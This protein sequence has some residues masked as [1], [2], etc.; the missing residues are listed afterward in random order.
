MSFACKSLSYSKYLIN[1]S[2]CDGDDNN[3]DDDVNYNNGGSELD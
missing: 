3:Y 1:D 2:C